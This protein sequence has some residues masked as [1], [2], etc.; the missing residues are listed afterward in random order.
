MSE[1]I[2]SKTTAHEIGI[3]AP[4]GFKILANAEFFPAIVE[5]CFIIKC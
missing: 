3:Q 4:L 5:C 2:L 1:E